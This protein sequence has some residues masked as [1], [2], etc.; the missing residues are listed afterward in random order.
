MTKKIFIIFILSIFFLSFISCKNSK[1]ENDNLVPQENNDEK[2]DD[3]GKITPG[4]ENDNPVDP[5]PVNPNPIEPDPIEP[6]PIE[7]IDMILSLE[8][9]DL[10]LPLGSEYE[11]N[12]SKSSNAVYEYRYDEEIIKIDGDTLKPLKAGETTLE[13]IGNQEVVD[14]IKVTIYEIP[15]NLSFVDLPK[16]IKLYDT[17]HIEVNNPNVEININSL[18]VDFDKDSSTV[19]AK[20]TGSFVVSAVF[21]YDNSYKISSSVIV[22]DIYKNASDVIVDSNYSDKKN[23]DEI[24]IDNI[25]YIYGKSLYSTISSAI[26]S[27]KEVKVIRTKENSVNINRSTLKLIGNKDE[28]IDLKINVSSGMKDITIS[29]FSFTKDS[30][31][32]F[33]GNNSNIYIKNNKFVNTTLNTTAWSA[34]KD[35]NSGVIEFKDSTDFHNNINILDNVFDNIGDCG[36]NFNSV[37]N[38]KCE[39]NKFDN[40][41]KD[42]IRLNNGVIKQR[43]IWKFNNNEFRNSPYSGLYFR[44]YSSDSSTFCHYVDITNNYFSAL[45]SANIE[46]SSAITFRNYQEGLSCINISY[47]TFNAC[48]K[49]IFLRNNAVKNN[50]ERFN[51]YVAY[52]VFETIPNKYYF[53]NLNSSDTVSTNPVQAKL[54]NN[55]YLDGS[56]NDITPK[57]EKFIGALSNTSI[58]N[59]QKNNLKQIELL[60]L[61]FVDEVLD[62]NNYNVNNYDKNYLEINN[63]KLKAIKE[64]ITNLVI[65]NVNY[66]IKIIKEIDLVV[67]FI[68]I[69]LGEVGYQ[70]MDANGKTGTSGNYTKYGAWYGINPGAWCAMYVSWCANQAGVSTSIIPKYAS[71]QIGMDWYKNKGLFQYKESYTPKAGDIMFM[72]SSGAS[73]TGIVLYCDGKTLYTVEGNT[74][75]CCACRKYDVNNAKITGYG[76]PQWPYYSPNGYNFSSGNP[77]DGSGHSTT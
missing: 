14:S 70:E 47:N 51:G 20:K 7:P 34:A 59:E 25:R 13:L 31:I 19:Y 4:D 9:D 50:Q 17:V 41:K 23:G 53:N 32:I 1:D 71:V 26:I 60:H 63:N 67:K 33:N 12:L 49:F 18:V 21:K 48:D 39:N 11:L 54:I 69:A 61:M 45:G 27:N 2:K 57:N 46:F 15:T 36:I 29:D 75:D 52:N 76:T 42:G 22:E 68:N 62:L 66:E 73:H 43:A 44:T 30:K 10:I 5:T 3:D 77:S 37:L 65:D 8:E 58:T 24:I 6:D 74:S 72:K 64:G 56:G 35:Y 38:L 40:F 55:V 28:N 16:K